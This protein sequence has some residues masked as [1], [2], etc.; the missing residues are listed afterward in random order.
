VLYYTTY[1]D[2]VERAPQ[3]FDS[4]TG[5]FPVKKPSQIRGAIE[6]IGAEVE[7]ALK[8]L[9]SNLSTSAWIKSPIY[10]A[11]NSSPHSEL[12]PTITPGASAVTEV[13]TLEFTSTTA[14][15]V[16]GD[17]TGVLS[18]GTTGS[19]YTSSYINIPNTAWVG[20]FLPGDLFYVRTYISERLIESI[21]SRLTA[22]KL[23]ES[24]YTD[25]QPN[26]VGTVDSLRRDAKADI[27][28]LLDQSKVLGKEPLKVSSDLE[29]EEVNYSVDELGNDVTTYL[30]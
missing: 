19:T 11:R 6:E 17:R 28:D 5:T 25:Q 4:D 24:V 2:V 12:L 8:R 14:F 16:K 29:Y 30:S 18:S 10:G 20:T 9:Y 27:N 15:S 22:A 7:S 26:Q 1:W 21:C 3:L 23:L 13:F